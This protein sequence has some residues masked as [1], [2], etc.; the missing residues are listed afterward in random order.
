MQFASE[1]LPT[2]IRKTSI[3]SR[4]SNPWR[5]PRKLF[6]I[7][8]EASVAGY[9]YARRLNRRACTVGIRCDLVWN[10]QP[11][12][13]HGRR[14]ARDPFC[15]R[16]RCS[17]RR[18]VRRIPTCSGGVC[19]QCLRAHRCGSRR[20]VAVGIAE[21]DQQ[22]FVLACRT[23]ENSRNRYPVVKL[24]ESMGR[25]RPRKSLRAITA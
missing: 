2:M 19:A 10:E 9:G 16:A 5:M 1:S 15:A 4:P 12:S 3:T 21:I 13:Q 17:F 20:V 24:I 25:L 11:L 14:L 18:N 22:A 8:A 7:A 23:K 6:G